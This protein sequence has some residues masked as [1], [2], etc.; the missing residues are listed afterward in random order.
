[1]DDTNLYKG[2]GGQE[3]VQA[4]GNHLGCIAQRGD[5]NCRSLS[6]CSHLLN[7]HIS[8]TRLEHTISSE[9]IIPVCREF[10][11]FCPSYA[12]IK[13]LFINRFVS[14]WRRPKCKGRLPMTYRHLISRRIGQFIVLLL[15]L[16][17]MLTTA[18]NTGRP[19]SNLIAT[20]PTPVPTEA[21][22]GW[23]DPV[24]G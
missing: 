3:Q 10:L 6:P 15:L 20:D 7:K 9:E 8:S 19:P 2:I 4:Q 21:P 5:V 22:D 16:L 11:P 17:M 13:C 12:G 18:L 1:M 23:S 14:N 24:G